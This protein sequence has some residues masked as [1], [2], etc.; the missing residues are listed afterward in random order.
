MLILKILG[1][2]TSYKYENINNYKQITIHPWNE[3]KAPICSLKLLS[4]KIWKSYIFSLGVISV[5]RCITR[6]KLLRQ[7]PPT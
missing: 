3:N 2:T 7:M 6:H 1:K 4:M 5:K